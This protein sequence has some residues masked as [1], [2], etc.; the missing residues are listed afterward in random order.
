[1]RDKL[2]WLG[3]GAIASTCHSAA[4]I[5]MPRFGADF[6]YHSNTYSGSLFDYED[7]ST[8]Y[9]RRLRASVKQDFTSWLSAKAST[10]Y[11]Y[12]DRKFELVDLYLEWSINADWSM[13]VGR[14]KEPFSMENVQSLKTQYMTERSAPGNALTYGRNYG[15]GLFY[16]GKR[17]TWAGAVTEEDAEDEG[18][19]DAYAATSRITYAPVLEDEYF[20]HL[21]AGYSQRDATERNYRPDANLIAKG[22]DAEV[23][24]PRLRGVDEMQAYNLELAGQ[25]R[26]FLVQA[27]AFKQQVDM[28][29]GEKHHL[30]GHYAVFLWT[31]TGNPRRYRDGEI[32]LG[33]GDHI[34]E[35]AIRYSH[36]DFVVEGDGDRG[37]TRA[38]AINYYPRSNIRFSLEYEY[39]T[40]YDYDEYSR[41][42]ERGESFNGRLQYLF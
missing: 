39:G 2:L 15:I 29:N 7:D 11:E 20:V 5:E 21:G 4:A 30:E 10:D 17:W 12:D 24:S 36:S 16:E 22:A 31:I 42:M 34:T 26:N 27:E 13:L 9:W 28:L 14:F 41:D 35:L 32:S 3:A 8:G 33:K 23:R 18:F 38:I 37:D 25:W 1:M 19:D 6:I 40:L